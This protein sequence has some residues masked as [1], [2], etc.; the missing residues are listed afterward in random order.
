[1]VLDNM[2]VRCAATCA[3]ANSAACAVMDMQ[4]SAAPA[5]AAAAGACNGLAAQGAVQQ[6]HCTHS[7]RVWL[8]K[9][10]PL[11]AAGAL[12]PRTLRQDACMLLAAY[13]CSS[14]SS[15]QPAAAAPAATSYGCT[16]SERPPQEQPAA[17]AVLQARLQAVAAVLSMQL[18]AG[19][20][21]VPTLP[22]APAAACS[23]HSRSCELGA[24][25][26]GC[27]RMTAP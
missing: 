4:A 25:A 17:A 27:Q 26:P 12:S 21:A 18:L 23:R 3:A 19:G 6:R 22:P 24:C 14:A 16:R 5:V 10:R 9:C 1:M 7:S 2:P 13:M 20:S 8:R 15:R 11:A